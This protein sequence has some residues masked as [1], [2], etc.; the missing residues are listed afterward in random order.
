VSSS[1]H[2]VVKEDSGR[3]LDDPRVAPL[4]PLLFYGDQL[5]AKEPRV[6]WCY[7]LTMNY[8]SPFSRLVGFVPAIADWHARMTLVKVIIH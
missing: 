3:N 2:H 1:S 4:I 8:Q 5:I 6:P 7:D